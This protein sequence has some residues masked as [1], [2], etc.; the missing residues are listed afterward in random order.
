M[1]GGFIGAIQFLEHL[2]VFEVV[3]PFLLVFTL[4]Y[5]FLE[6]TRIFGTEK[7]YA[8]DDKYREK[9]YTGSRKNLNAMASFVIAFFVVASSQ[10][11]A[12]INQSL[13][14]MVLLLILVFCFILVVGSF[15]KQTEEGFFLEDPWK[16]IFMVIAFIAIAFIFL[17]ALGWLEPVWNW[18]T[19]AGT[20]EAVATVVLIALIAGFIAWISRDPK[21]SRGPAKSED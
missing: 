5:A 19:K 13:S 7:Y 2:G 6:K 3:L 21:K 4:I 18:I 11:V 15:H 20:S 8:Y 17:N 14:H 16:T 12:V 1:A 10:L 9:G